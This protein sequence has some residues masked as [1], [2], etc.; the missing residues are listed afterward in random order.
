[1]AAIGYGNISELHYECGG[2]LLS[3][4]FVV[5]AAHCREDR[6]RYFKNKL[7]QITSNQRKIHWGCCS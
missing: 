1:M 3:E 4:N 5:T 2:T 7:F 6:V